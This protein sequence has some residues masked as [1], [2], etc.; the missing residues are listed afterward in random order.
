MANL[1]LGQ[2]RA[3]ILGSGAALLA[4]C[5]LGILVMTP[6][7]VYT[8]YLFPVIALGLGGWFYLTNPGLYFGFTWW[9][10]FLTPFVRRFV[11]Y[12]VGFFNQTS[13]IML[14]PMLVTG[15]SLF[16]VLRYANRFQM[17]LYQPMALLF[18]ALL[19]GYA[20]GIVRNGPFPATLALLEWVCP[21]LF[22][23]HVLVH[24]R[25]Y[26]T[27]RRV[28]RSV[29]TWGILIMG[30]YGIVQ[31]FSPLPWDRFWMVESR[32][33]TIGRP[34]PFEVRIFST[35]NS[36]GPFAG[37]LMVGLMVLFEARGLTA[38]LAMAPGFVSFLL[39]LVRS[40]WG[41]FAVAL[42]YAAA[43]LHSRLRL[44]LLAVLGVGALL[45]MPLLMHSAVSERVAP[46]VETLGRLGADHSFQARSALYSIAA[47]NSVTEPIGRGFGSFG[48]AANFNEDG[49][50]SFDSGLM[51]IPF[52]L[53]W[54]GAALYVF[55]WAWLLFG[56]LRLR[57]RDT[58]QFTVI[59]AAVTM[60]MVA[61]MVFSNQLT[62]VVGMVT[63]TFTALAVCG[64][65]HYE[66][67]REEEDAPEPAPAEP[68]EADL[69][70]PVYT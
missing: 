24:H 9:L 69:H 57:S 66:R 59:A 2:T 64:G 1:V 40:A 23:F 61:Q 7:A 27:F 22:A 42:G 45:S 51:I 50:A 26:L 46:R 63:W 21:L 56:I 67:D 15:L 65:L 55:G 10:W 29:F 25:Q 11:D 5:A 60:G 31:Y 35:L 16:S 37:I 33:T 32:M 39:S 36:P 52:T 41:G 19:Y 47:L 43:R 6:Y 30:L 70:D 17:R 48:R 53:G 34:E 14:T 3:T 28:T 62:G 58:D 13:Y 68:A 12:E 54:P 18:A 20:V 38:R 4:L 44:R 8:N 49:I